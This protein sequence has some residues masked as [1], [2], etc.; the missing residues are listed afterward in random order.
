MLQASLESLNSCDA[1]TMSQTSLNGLQTVIMNHCLQ[2][3]M[4]PFAAS[5][6]DLR[7]IILRL[8]GSL[9]STCDL[10]TENVIFDRNILLTLRSTLI[11]SEPHVRRAALGF[12]AQLAQSADVAASALI[13]EGFV[14]FAAESLRLT[15]SKGANEL[16]PDILS[17][18]SYL[19]P[20]S[21]NDQR[22]TPMKKSTVA[23]LVPYV[24]KRCNEAPASGW[25]EHVPI[26]Y[27]ELLSKISC[28]PGI[29]RLLSFDEWHHVIAPVMRYA[30]LVEP[31]VT[32][33]SVQN[34]TDFIQ[35][36]DVALPPTLLNL[37]ESLVRSL[38]HHEAF[39]SVVAQMCLHL[40]TMVHTTNPR[41]YLLDWMDQFGVKALASAR[42]EWWLWCGAIAERLRIFADSASLNDESLDCVVQCLHMLGALPLG[43]PSHRSGSISNQSP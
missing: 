20:Y 2:F 41:L 13:R 10:A 40:S 12:F 5:R 36:A 4:S 25:E 1:V 30:T 39:S 26:Q 21:Q 38:A 22:V 24:A 3:L 29:N 37:C 16:E 35:S 15:S 14:D 42:S 27:V 43:Q 7:V 28:S 32:I 6:P 23:F 33:R 8:V 18:I 19:L 31:H 17:F 11:D 34:I 9:C